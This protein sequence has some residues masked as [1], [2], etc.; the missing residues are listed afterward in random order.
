MPPDVLVDPDDG[1][2]IEA[3]GVPD[4]DTPTFSQDRIVGG[5]PRHSETFSDTSDG[6][7]LTYEPFQSPPQAAARQLRPRLGGLAD[8][9]APHMPAFG[10]PVAANRN[11]Q[12]RRAPPQ[13]FM[14]QPPNYRVPRRAL[15]STA[16][17]PPVRLHNPARQ[18]STIRLEP[19]PDDLQTKLIESGK[20][21]QIRRGEGSVGH[22]EVFQMGGIGTSIIGRPRP[23]THHRR[24][25]PH[26]TLNCEEPIRCYIIG[27][28]VGV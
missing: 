17:A 21:S 28:V 12:R 15:A 23:L 13:R 2:P 5:V 4:Q 8:V 11:Q 24:A 3:A 1:D 9:L 18:H 25:N 14:G 16:T 22:V 7:V 27:G 10:A 19:L 6:E 20:R 26:Y